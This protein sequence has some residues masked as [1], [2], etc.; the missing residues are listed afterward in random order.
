MG[1]L[2]SLKRGVIDGIFYSAR[3]SVN[4]ELNTRRSIMRIDDINYPIKGKP[5]PPFMGVYKPAIEKIAPICCGY[6]VGSLT[7]I[8]LMDYLAHLAIANRYYHTGNIGVYKR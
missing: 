4:Y 1:R 6:L 7:S 2:L 3:I 8:V 5:I